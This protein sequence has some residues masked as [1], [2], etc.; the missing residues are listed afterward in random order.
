MSAKTLI[1]L[2]ILYVCVVVVAAICVLYQ[3][4]FAAQICADTDIEAR[5]VTIRD[6]IENMSEKEYCNTF[7]MEQND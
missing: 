3:Q 5:Y 6:Y 1:F 4:I 7:F 2:I